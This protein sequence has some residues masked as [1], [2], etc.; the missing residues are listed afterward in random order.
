MCVPHPLY[1]FITMSDVKVGPSVPSSAP[2]PEA[3]NGHVTIQLQYLENVVMEALW[4]HQFRGLFTASRCRGSVYPSKYCNCSYFLNYIYSKECVLF[5]LRLFHGAFFLFSFFPQPGD[6]IVVMAQTLQKLFLHKLSQMPKED[7][8]TELAEGEPVRKKKKTHSSSSQKSQVSEVV[9]KQRVTAIPPDIPQFQAPIWSII[10][11]DAPESNSSAPLYKSGRPMK[12]PKKD[13]PFTETKRTRAPDPLRCCQNILKELLSMKHSEYAWPFYEPVDTLAL[14]LHDYH[15]IIKEP[16]DLGTIKKKMDQREYANAEDF[17]ADKIFEAC[18]SKVPRHPESRFMSKQSISRRT[19]TGAGTLSTSLS[20]DGVRSSKKKR[21]WR[22]Y[23]LGV[24]EK[25]IKAIGDEVEELSR[26]PRPKPKKRKRETGEKGSQ[27]KIKY[28]KIKPIPEKSATSSSTTSTECNK[29]SVTS[30]MTYQEKKQIKLDLYKLPEEELRNVFNFIYSREL[31][32]QQCGLGEV[33]VDLD[34][35]KDSTLRALQRFLA[36]TLE[37]MN[38][39][40]QNL[41]L[42]LIYF[43]HFFLPY[44]LLLLIHFCYIT[45]ISATSSS[46]LNAFSAHFLCF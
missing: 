2:P 17:C 15:N 32:Q 39:E 10:Q 7:V 43:H 33:V 9:V 36:A 11:T 42:I 31:Y 41:S 8:D 37:K 18:Y 29:P 22:D 5:I 3:N 28:L 38:Q 14:G 40:A 16:M 24:I 19:G 27:L 12:R 1:Y 45:S 13:L 35:M 20:C 30:P 4:Q 21:L 44:F 26:K 34:T 6:D 46:N 23:E 25:Q